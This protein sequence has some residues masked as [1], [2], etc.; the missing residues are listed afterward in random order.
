MEIWIGH[1]DTLLNALFVQKQIT[2]KLNKNKEEI[3]VVEMA[4]QLRHTLDRVVFV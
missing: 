1:S 3:T 2:A 4:P